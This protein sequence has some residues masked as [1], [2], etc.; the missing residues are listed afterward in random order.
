[1]EKWIDI[2][3]LESNYKNY[4]S[5]NNIKYFNNYSRRTGKINIYKCSHCEFRLKVIKL[6]NKRL[7]KI[8]LTKKRIF[9]LW[10][11]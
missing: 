10:K 11:S 8:S 4:Y 6:Y 7:S 1:M 9:Y 3:I 2:V 5:M